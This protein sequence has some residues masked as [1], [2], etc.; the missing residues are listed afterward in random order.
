MTRA[1][2]IRPFGIKR[3][4]S[5]REVDFER[6]HAELIQPALD[7]AGIGGSTTGE[8]I[9]AG[10]IREDMFSLILEADVV[11]ADVT[12]HNANVFYELGIR[13]AFRKKSTLMIRGDLTADQVPFD[14]STDR[15]F[16]YPVDAPGGSVEALTNSIR[17]SLRSDRATD[18]PVFQLLPGLDEADP[19]QVVVVPLD[20]AEEVARARGAKALGWLRLL[21]DE[22][23]PLRFGVEGLRIVG[24]AQW[25][26]K[27]YEGARRTW[28]V[29]RAA[30][31]GD[32]D[33][34]LALANVC[35]RL[36][37]EGRPEML[38]ESEHA[39]DRLLATDLDRATRAEALSLR[40]RN[41]KTV[42]QTQFADIGD[43][44]ARRTA[45]MNR[46]LLESFEAYRSAFC[47]D[48]NHHYPG[49]VALQMGTIL[50]DLSRE[51]TWPDAFDSDAEAERYRIGLDDTIARLR[52]V[53][54]LSVDNALESGPQDVWARV[55]R[56]D[57][58]FLS[59][60]ARPRR[61]VRSYD[62][63]IS[64]DEPFAWDAAR[65]QL[66][67]FRTVGIRG[68]LASEIIAT[69]DAKFD[70]QP[71]DARSTTHLVVFAGHRIDE[72]DRPEPRFPASAER[73]A[74]DLIRDAIEQLRA[75]DA[76]IR[77]I[78]SAAPGAD[79]LAHEVF[80]ELGIPAEI[81]LP[82]PAEEFARQQFAD[83]DDWRNRYLQLLQDGRVMML[84][85]RP[86]LPRWLQ[87][88]GLD[89][90]ERGNE[91]VIKLAE[92]SGADRI[93][94]VV[95][96]DGR[97]AEGPGGTAHMVDLVR[98][99]GRIHLERIDSTPLTEDAARPAR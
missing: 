16:E 91:W 38:A 61:V 56:A 72:P 11:I 60:A 89:P 69:V 85:D 35:E 62:H 32:V 18:S 82:M 65:G 83:L 92:T 27:D 24:H 25:S 94:A 95:L 41:L 88:S 99:S 26:L 66:E 48:L 3:D 21:A 93:T 13:H 15:Y 20:F 52:T 9:D 33:A 97:P 31:P 10:N 79:I 39:V 5:G 29:V 22:V 76:E 23:R 75:D 55:T 8:M 64:A 80:A 54:E 78:A 70:E 44:A 40:G 63:A 42:W 19:S 45:A 86:G 68:E 37:R 36:H 53:V 50:L 46:T 12:V 51:E 74:R 34:D 28:E 47:V 81:C 73:A 7:A 2:V 4:S 87:A 6:V 1:F 43:L 84:S 49:L 59:E 71:S 14:L 30:R 90:W 58:L 57:A 17:A 77:A 98:R 96:W 67:L